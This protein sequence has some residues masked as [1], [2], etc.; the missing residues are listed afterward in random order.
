M[1]TP[2]VETPTPPMTQT[3]QP[4][5]SLALLTPTSIGGPLPPSSTS[6]STLSR[7]PSSMQDLSTTLASTGSHLVLPLQSSSRVATHMTTIFQERFNRS[8]HTSAEI[9][10]SKRCVW[11]PTYFMTRMKMTWESKAKDRLWDLL[12]D[13]R[14]KNKRPPWID[15]SYW[16]EI[17]NHWNTL[18]YKA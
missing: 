11:D 7:A 12:G 1:G 14:G 2:S 15:E 10:Q 13:A 8:Y 17:L 6:Q 5:P 16:A 18:E 9:P 4:T 3:S